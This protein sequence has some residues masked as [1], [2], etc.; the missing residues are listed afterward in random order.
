MRSKSNDTSSSSSD[1]PVLKRA[2]AGREKA[3]NNLKNLKITDP[4]NK[5]DRI[6]SAIDK[7]G[8]KF[9]E[10]E[11]ERHQIRRSVDENFNAGKELERKLKR[12][13]VHAEKMEKL[14][15]EAVQENERLRQKIEQGGKDTKRLLRRV[16]RVEAIAKDAQAALET[17]A[18]V[19][20]TDHA[21]AKQTQM[22]MI[23]ASEA[24]SDL[25]FQVDENGQLIFED[26]D[27]ALERHLHRAALRGLTNKETRSENVDQPD[28]N[29]KPRFGYG[30]EASDFEDDQ[31]RM[32]EK[33]WW[34]KSL[35]LSQSVAVIAL[36]GAFAIGLTVAHWSSDGASVENAAYTL[37]QDGRLVK[38]DLQTGEVIPVMMDIEKA[39]AAQQREQALQAQQQ[40][41][42]TST[43]EQPSQ[44][45]TVFS[46]SDSGVP[47]PP[48]TP[49]DIQSEAATE[50]AI[51]T[52]QTATTLAQEGTVET[53]SETQDAQPVTSETESAT[54]EAAATSQ[55]PQAPMTLEQRIGRDEDLS[56][57]LRK[58]ED[59]AFAIIP[60]AQH[61][62]AALY[63]AGQGVSQNYQRAALWFREA[64]ENGIA[65]A[66]YNLGV[67]YHQGLG[68]DED[69]VTALNWYRRAALFG[70]PEAQYNLGIAY[71]E[72]M[73]ARYNPNMAAAFFQQAALN[74]IV[75][76]AYNLGLI[77]EN[78]LL[79]QAHLEQAMVWYR[80][81][82]DLGSQDARIA[83]NTLAD[84]LGVLP[85]RA[86]LMGNSTSY[87]EMIR[88]LLS[89]NGNA[90]G[91]FYKELPDAPGLDL[92][93]IEYI[94]QRQ[95]MVL[96]EIQ[97]QLAARDLYPGAQDGL[98]GPRTT[99]AIKTFQALQ[100]VSEADG[101]PSLQLLKSMLKAAT[102]PDVSKSN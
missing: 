97:A 38:I 96:A 100:G 77:L 30:I 73:G 51:V 84:K 69:L 76:A 98:I 13:S 34:Q 65:N 75:E 86:G 43:S 83:L 94:P 33:P 3:K 42:I 29:I 72:G 49:R 81:A 24:L 44:Q 52:E 32:D 53:A 88:P 55:E 21:I 20:L 4:A 25:D 41:S 79:G 15:N 56:P 39:L 70:H 50:A 59:E 57:A 45:P 2:S 66:S 31:D 58:I 5:N 60:E 91:V 10:S 93:L 61:D 99:E 87:T 18:L 16:E 102:A 63:T 9:V 14:L 68:V 37:L 64:A 19:L 1:K 8:Q 74:G 11:A 85:E 46:L 80:V 54:P 22:P 27:D 67:M 28:A 89:N 35:R 78:G 90:S 95:Q 36:M 12:Q 71:I 23:E 92:N 40:A 62:L 7:L 48:L 17:K 47:I 101:T 82:T 26:N 6:M